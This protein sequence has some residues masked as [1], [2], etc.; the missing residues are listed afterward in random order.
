MLCRDVGIGFHACNF[1]E[2]RGEDE[3]SPEEFLKSKGLNRVGQM[4][5]L[6][7]EAAL[8]KKFRDLNPLKKKV[9]DAQKKS[10][11]AEKKVQEKK[12]AMAAIP[13]KRRELRARKPTPGT[14]ACKQARRA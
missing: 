12:D 8:N 3:A 13:E 4:Y 5:V 10:D 14:P 2:A 7:D 9:L 1:R 11:A 6:P